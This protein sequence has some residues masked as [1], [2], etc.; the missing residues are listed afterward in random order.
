MALNAGDILVYDGTKWENSSEGSAPSVALGAALTGSASASVTLVSGSNNI[1]GMI[2][3]MSGTGPS[4]GQ[5][6]KVTFPSGYFSVTPYVFLQALDNA[7]ATLGYTVGDRV[8]TGFNIY[9]Q[10]TPAASATYNLYYW[11]VG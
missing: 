4:S 10:N 3:I 7:G 2:T 11:V 1:R 8:S 6:V 5:L 9:A